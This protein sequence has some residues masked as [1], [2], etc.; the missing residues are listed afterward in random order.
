MPSASAPRLAIVHIMLWT[1]CTAGFLGVQRQWLSGVNHQFRDAD[2]VFDIAFAFLA[3]PGLAALCVLPVWRRAGY[4]F[5]TH[6]GEWLLLM[7]GC[8]V[9]LVVL[10]SLA[11][12]VLFTSGELLRMSDPYDYGSLALFL[13]VSKAINCAV[14]TILAIVSWLAFVSLRGRTAWRWFFFALAVPLT[15][16]GILS[17]TEL[18][19]SST[20][21][22]DPPEW[23][24]WTGRGLAICLPVVLLIAMIRDFR[25]PERLPWTHWLGVAVIVLQ[26]GTFI[27]C[28]A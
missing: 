6:G 8:L 22:L 14:V 12:R 21:L 27:L 25:S 18:I 4:R 28:P 3:G 7:S 5:P 16:F 11:L 26:V 24:A 13:K 17:S 9:V 15:L 2:L 23:V 10:G 1:A 20:L 19:A